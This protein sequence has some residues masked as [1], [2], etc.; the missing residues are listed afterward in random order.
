MSDTHLPTV[1]HRGLARAAG[2]L[3]VAT[4]AAGVGYD[5]VVEV[6]GPDG[7]PRPG[8]VLEVDG[9]RMVVQVLGGT[10]GL[11][12]PGTAV[13][14][15]GETA[16]LGVGA[17]LVGRVLDGSGRPIDGGPPPVPEAFHDVD[18]PV[19]HSWE[20]AVRGFVQLSPAYGDAADQA[21]SRGWST[22]S[23]P[24]RHLDLLS[25]PGPVARAVLAILAGTG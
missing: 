24:G 5:E 8:R 22:L 25:D 1:E 20:P 6:V 9:D 14:T 21:R 7:E 11:D 19:P 4:G 16:R 12:L 10:Q 17:D 15:R 3:V 18:V 23:L 13:R 2:P